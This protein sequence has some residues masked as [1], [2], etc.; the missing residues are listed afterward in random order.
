LSISADQEREYYDQV[1][2]RFLALPDADLAVDAH[3]LRRDLDNPVHP[4]RE[5]RR[6]FA[7]VLA[8]FDG[9]PL[10]AMRVLDYGCGPGDWGLY[11][12]SRGARVTCLDLSPVAAQLVE[13]RARASGL[14]GLVEPQA[15][16]ASDL[17]PWPD[18]HF[19][20]VFGS[21]ALH[22]TLKYGNAYAELVRVIRLGGQLVLAETFGANPLLNAA[23]RFGWWWRKQ[24]ADSGEDILFGPDELRLLAGD[25]ETLASEPLNLLAMAKRLYRGRFA[26]A[27]GQ[28]KIAALER[29]DER[30]LSFAP[31]LRRYCGEIFWAGA[32]RPAP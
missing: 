16:D 17:T 14:A 6:L 26:E 15:R 25:F 4:I 30:L 24:A 5:R 28:N 18:G 12:A 13:R 21:A 10:A 23:R 29:L 8:H 20:L 3:T 22:H 2:R 32:K 9:L 31:G 27:R 1:Y 7:R 19:D 11:C